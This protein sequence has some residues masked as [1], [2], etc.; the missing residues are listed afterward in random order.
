MTFK[1]IQQFDEYKDSFQDKPNKKETDDNKEHIVV[2]EMKIKTSYGSY[3][4][5][6]IVYNQIEIVFMK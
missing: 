5:N 6:R 3:I 2:Y 4:L 1:I